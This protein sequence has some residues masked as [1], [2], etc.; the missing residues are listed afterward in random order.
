MNGS[1]SLCPF[2][3]IYEVES[4]IDFPATAIQNDFNRFTRSIIVH[5][6]I[7]QNDQL[8]Q[9]IINTCVKD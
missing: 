5:L 3:L 4:G 9:V 7:R 2:D 1:R 6:H 8:K